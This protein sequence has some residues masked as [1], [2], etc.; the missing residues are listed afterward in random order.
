MEVENDEQLNGHIENYNNEK[1]DDGNMKTD[2]SEDLLIVLKIITIYLKMRGAAVLAN[3]S[4]LDK[5][6]RK[7]KKELYENKRETI[8]EE[9]YVAFPEDQFP[10]E[11]ER[12][13]RVEKEV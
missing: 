13:S 9:A 1:D 7:F 8:L 5:G 12:E 10:E 11:E 6:Y 4:R 2:F 3:N